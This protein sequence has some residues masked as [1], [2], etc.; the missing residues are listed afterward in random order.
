MPETPSPLR[1]PGG[2]TIYAK[3]IS[4][5]IDN[6][7]LSNC[8]FVEA[9]AGGAGAAI[10]LLLSEKIKSIFL[11]DLDPSIYSFWYSI[12][13]NTDDFLRLMYQTPITVDEWRKQRD[14]YR[15]KPDDHLQLGFATF[16]LNR[17]NRSGVILANPIG[18][19]EQKGKYK[20]D[21]RYKKEKL[22]VKIRAISDRKDSIKIY[23]LDA[24]K[25][26][27]ELKQKHRNQKLLIY[28]DPP[29]FK[30][31]K[32]LYFNHYRH[33][34]HEELSH[35]IRNCPFP[36]LLSYDKQPEIV[37]LYNSF[38][39]YVKDLRYYL[40]KKTI[41]QELIISNL[42]MPKHLRVLHS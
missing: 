26:I 5:V 29:Y 18:G 14:I 37:D 24:C 10:T 1:Y 12:I 34:D 40:A 19:L 11:N 7:D 13:Y 2:K 41:A 35:H 42:L 23:N 33:N 31:G 39:I 38:P 9:F 20:I 16:F 4:H 25:F 3:M 15:A 22:E 27:E 21:E 8:T 6:N 28:F 30:K 32:L 17:C 36:W